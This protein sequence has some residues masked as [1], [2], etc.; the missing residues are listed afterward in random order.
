MYPDVQG[1]HS[2]QI[3]VEVFSSRCWIRIRRLKFGKNVLLEYRDPYAF[4][5]P[6][7][8]STRYIGEI[9]SVRRLD[10]ESSFDN[11]ASVIGEIF[12]APR[13]T[14]IEYREAG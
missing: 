6:G 2:F 5:S 1:E 8:T 11:C 14:Q 12:R 3:R 4:R 9:F 10:D 7:K 13:E